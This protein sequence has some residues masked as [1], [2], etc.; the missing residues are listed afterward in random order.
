MWGEVQP[1]KS[2]SGKQTTKAKERNNG[3]DKEILKWNG[4]I[5]RTG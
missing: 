4:I 1:P 3:T 2:R 5:N